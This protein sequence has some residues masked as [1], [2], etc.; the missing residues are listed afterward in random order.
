M[1]KHAVCVAALAVAMLSLSSLEGAGGLATAQVAKPG[2]QAE[3]EKTLRAAKEEGQVTVYFDSSAT[4]FVEPFRKQFPEINLVSVSIDSP[5]LANRVM[6]ERRAGKYLVDIVITGANP[7]YQ[8]YYA[9]KILEPITTAFILPEVVDES[10]WLQGKHW[11]IDTENRYVFVYLGNVARAASYNTKSVNPAQFKSYWDLLKPEWKGKIIAR[12]IR[13]P[14]SGGDAVRF[15]YHTPELGPSFVRRLFSEGGL[16]L[17]GDNRQGV[18]WLGQGKFV[19]GLFFGRIELARAQGLPVD[20]LD[21]HL[22]KE[23]APLGIGPG[24]AVLINRAPHP[25]AAK[26]FIN[27]FLSRDGQMTYQRD[28]ARGGT[29]ADSMRTDI[30]KDDVTPAYRRRANGKYLFVATPERTDMLPIYK[31]VNEALAEK[32]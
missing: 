30:S 11:Y 20:E 14:G 8:V 3:W 26:V 19:L 12:D 2:W 32:K 7:N 1:N 21:P 5:Q 16:T 24:T 17:T 22:F 28:A 31:V 4:L 18:D 9:A 25:N 13:R 10:K 27:W 6:A 29:G 23:G 15:F